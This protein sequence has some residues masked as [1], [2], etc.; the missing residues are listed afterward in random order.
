MLQAALIVTEKHSSFINAYEDSRKHILSGIT[1]DNL[2]R[3][4]NA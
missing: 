1:Y 4:Q 2:K 3:I